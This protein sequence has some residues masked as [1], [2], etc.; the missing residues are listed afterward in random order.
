MGGTGGKELWDFFF[1]YPKCSTALS[2]SLSFKRTMR[3]EIEKKAQ[4]G[5]KFDVLSVTAKHFIAVARQS[6][7]F[8]SRQVYSRGPCGLAT[9]NVC[10]GRGGGEG[11]LWDEESEKKRE[12]GG[13]RRKRTRVRFITWRWEEKEEEK[14][15]GDGRGTIFVPHNACM[16]VRPV[17]I[18]AQKGKEEEKKKKCHWYAWEKRRKGTNGCWRPSDLV[19]CQVGSFLEPFFVTARITGC[20]GAM[21]A[22]MKCF[23]KIALIF[24]ILCPLLK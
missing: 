23:D 7:H 19:R 18:Q 6:C 12:R 20:F 14:E 10:P 16:H 9:L 8:F 17:Y 15:G 24:D 1:F 3:E 22:I 2:L 21:W 5:V 4:G 11:P 13:R